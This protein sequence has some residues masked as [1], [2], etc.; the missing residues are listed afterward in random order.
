MSYLCTFV[1]LGLLWSLLVYSGNGVIVLYKLNVSLY[2]LSNA[3]DSP[4]E[5]NERWFA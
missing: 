2:L 1:D 5:H 3:E 4:E